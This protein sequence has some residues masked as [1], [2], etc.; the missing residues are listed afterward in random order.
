MTGAELRQRIERVYITIEGRGDAKNPAWG[1]ASWFARTVQNEAGKP[2]AR[3]TVNRWLCG[4]HA[5][6][7]WVTTHLRGLEWEADRVRY[8]EVD[9]AVVRAKYGLNGRHKPRGSKGGP[10]IAPQR[11]R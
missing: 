9:R 7:A 6:P 8:G 10:G 4:V 1:S 11:P 2:L 5:V 3:N